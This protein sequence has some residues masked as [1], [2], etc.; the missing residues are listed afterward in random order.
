MFVLVVPVLNDHVSSSIRFRW[1]SSCVR[2]RST[3]FLLHSKVSLR[4]ASLTV[5][6][7]S[8]SRCWWCASNGLQL[9]VSN[10]I[11]HQTRKSCQ[12]RKVT[13]VTTV[14]F[15]SAFPSRV[16]H[17]VWSAGALWPRLGARAVPSTSRD[18]NG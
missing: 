2:N 16:A 5:F 7:E 1:C 17:Y 12:S 11:Q 9:E 10:H 3:V 6:V 14:P 4:I 13:T 8:V 15:I 18:W